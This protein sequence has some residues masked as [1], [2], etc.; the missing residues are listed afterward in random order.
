MT[1]TQT[2]RKCSD[3]THPGT[4]SKKT[5]K[6][7]FDPAEPVIPS[8]ALTALLAKPGE[9]NITVRDAP[10]NTS[11]QATIHRNGQNITIPE[12]PDRITRTMMAMLAPHPQGWTINGVPA[13]MIK[14]PLPDVL[15]SVS[16][17]TPTGWRA[18]VLNSSADLMPNCRL[19][20][21][22][23]WLPGLE[24]LAE[25][26]LCE[27]PSTSENW[28]PAGK[29]TLQ[30]M[31]H[32]SAATVELHQ[33]SIPIEHR[34]RE[35]VKAQ[36][37]KLSPAAKHQLAE[38]RRHPL[39]PPPA[40]GPVWIKPQNGSFRDISQT[41]QGAVPIIV[42]GTP[43]NLN[44]GKELTWAECTSA[45]IA[46]ELANT[47]LVPVAAAYRGKPDGT[48]HIEATPRG[49]I[50]GTQQLDVHI[51]GQQLTLS[52][53]GRKRLS[54]PM[55]LLARGHYRPH[56]Q[57]PMLASLQPDFRPDQDQLAD[58]LTRCYSPSL[59]SIQSARP[60]NAWASTQQI[61]KMMQHARE[62]A[63]RLLYCE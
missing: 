49:G 14:P 20:G 36:L 22:M 24:D 27:L 62:T 34:V 52:L 39:T 26:Y 6:M 10:P 28:S 13:R 8:L 42:H 55:P 19:D 35:L 61:I 15:I 58:M 60:D 5:T 53:N 7:L 51:N 30:P 38:A 1:T 16:I 3:T 23:T 43:I 63:H 12:E 2:E 25:T 11:Y 54:L 45:L 50:P 31:P 9:R 37:P 40:R 18:A 59:K 47:K 21:L 33:M 32:F 46:L 4:I 48:I 57:P 17:Q 44:Y 41:R 56:R 29:V